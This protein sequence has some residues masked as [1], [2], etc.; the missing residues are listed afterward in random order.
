MWICAGARGATS[1]TQTNVSWSNLYTTNGNTQYAEL[2]VG[3]VSGSPG[4][5]ATVNFASSTRVQAFGVE[6]TTAFST[7][8]TAATSTGNASRGAFS[9]PLTT[10]AGDIVVGITSNN[11]SAYGMSMPNVPYAVVQAGGQGNG[12]ILSS[13]GCPIYSQSMFDAAS[14]VI[15]ALVIIS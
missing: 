13:P 10:S 8:G 4:T 12:F 11:S 7:A 1:I 2:W 15:Q 5:T 6:V 14:N 9:G 3:V